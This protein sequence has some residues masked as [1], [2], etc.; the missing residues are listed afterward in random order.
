MYP[1]NRPT[2]RPTFAPT[3][4]EFRG[5]V[6]G[7]MELS[8]LSEKLGSL[9][10]ISWEEVTENFVK[11]SPGIKSS[12]IVLR[13]L[14]ANVDKQFSVSRT[15]TVPGSIRR[16][17]QEEATATRIDSVVIQYKIIMLY[18][19]PSEMDAN[20]LVWS[21][22]DDTERQQDYISELRD[23]SSSFEPVKQVEVAV[24]GWVPPPTQAPAPEPEKKT[25][26]AVIAGGAVGGVALIILIFLFVFRRQGKT[27]AGN[28]VTA[29]QATPSTS[30]N[31]K[32]STEILVEPQ[33]DVS[34]LGDPMYGQGG[35]MMGGIERDEMTAT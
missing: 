20:E 13:T 21:A 15:Q 24:D 14:R 32:V 35:M 8:P 29:S 6:T 12:P 19:S 7:E 23:R 34:T 4:P 18:Q 25:N 2:E 31:I 28:E 27:T 3:F 11:S 17:L 33:D 22:F 10:Q 1:T 9:A 30:K 16:S 26:I 5:E